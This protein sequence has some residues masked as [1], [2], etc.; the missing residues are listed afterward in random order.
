MGKILSCHIHDTI[1]IACLY[2][3]NICLQLSNQQ[4]VQGKAMT[5]NTLPNKTENLLVL[6]GDQTINVDLS[7]IVTMKAV[8][9]NP[10]FDLVEFR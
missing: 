2:G 8:T 5:T 9:Q 3:F 1:E 4:T 10:H 7:D 6:V